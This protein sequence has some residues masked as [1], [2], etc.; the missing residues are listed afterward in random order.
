MLYENMLF[1]A[2]GGLTYTTNPA[3]V[4]PHS[5]NLILG[6]GN[7]GIQAMLQLKKKV[8]RDL[9]GDGPEDQPTRFG[10]LHFLGIDADPDNAQ[11]LDAE[12]FF[13]LADGSLGT[14]LRNKPLLEQDPALSWLDLENTPI[15]MMGNNHGGV[16]SLGRYL[17]V[18]KAGALAQV[19]YARCTA[20]L[21]HNRDQRLNVFL[22]T[23]L[24]GTIG[25][26]CYVDTCYL[27]RCL[28]KDSRWDL[29]IYG[30]FFLPDMGSIDT[31]NAPDKFARSQS[32]AR[33]YAALKELDY[34]RNLRENTDRFTMRY[35]EYL[36]VDTQEPPVDVCFLLAEDRDKAMNKVTE[37][38]LGALAELQTDPLGF[39]DI[40]F[41]GRIGD[42]QHGVSYMPPRSGAN[43]GYFTLGIAAAEH[44]DTL[45]LNY[46]GCGFF[47]EFFRFIDPA[48]ST[49]PPTEIQGFLKRLKL[50]APSLYRML[51]TGI[52]DV[53]LPA[54]DKKELAAQVM[55]PKGTLNMFWAQAGNDWL[56]HCQA[57]L[58]A[59]VAKLVQPVDYD[60]PGASPDS[61]CKEI[62]FSLRREENPF[63][64]AALLRALYEGDRSAMGEAIEDAENT[65]SREKERLRQADDALEQAKR[66]F[67]S[68]MPTTARYEAYYQAARQRFNRVLCIQTIKQVI[69]VLNALKEQLRSMDDEY[70][71]PLTQILNGLH[72]TFEANRNDPRAFTGEGP[73][74]CLT[75]LENSKSRM[76]DAVENMPNHG[77]TDLLEKLHQAKPAVLAREPEQLR[78]LVSVHIALT[79]RE[80]LEA[81]AHKTLKPSP[82][83]MDLPSADDP[84]RRNRLLN[85]LIQE[86]ILPALQAQAKPAFPLI[87]TLGPSMLL[88]TT[89]LRI[90]QP[91]FGMTDRCYT[92][93]GSDRMTT[94]YSHPSYASRFILEQW[95]AGFPLYAYDGLLRLKK[96]YDTQSKGGLH[97]HRDWQTLLPEPLPCSVYPE[98]ATAEAEAQTL[99]EAAEKQEILRRTDFDRYFFITRD[100]P[101]EQVDIT[102]LFKDD[103]PDPALCRKALEALQT[104]TARAEEEATRIHF[105]EKHADPML[106]QRFDVDRLVLAPKLLQQVRRELER[107]AHRAALAETLANLPAQGAAYDRDLDEFC[108]G[109]C[110]GLL[111]A[112]AVPNSQA[113]DPTALVFCRFINDYKELV[114][115][116]FSTRTTELG[117]EFPLYAAFADWRSL[118]RYATPREDLLSVLEA[119]Q[120]QPQT[121][122]DHCIARNLLD[123][124]NDNALEQL[125]ARLRDPAQWEIRRF[126]MG[127][128]RHLD[129][130]KEAAPC[131]PE[132]DAQLQPKLRCLPASPNRCCQVLD[133]Q[134]GKILLYYPAT[135]TQLVYDPESSLPRPL[136]P[137]MKVWDG[138]DWADP[139]QS[140][141]LY[142]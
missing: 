132:E 134:D 21:M 28:A 101:E 12:E 83:T 118:N 53:Q 18:K 36:Q 112:P 110:F 103:R 105:P 27:L 8:F 127:L 47:R 57:K 98:L 135:S 85:I 74:L 133:L 55:P 102:T 73:Y 31:A 71:R 15:P 46:L 104:A 99:L 23:D 142:L 140:D 81:P 1:S 22:F 120:T 89:S 92:L 84:S 59:A 43:A 40:P 87:P 49:V 32:N 117:R 95:Y 39:Q 52:P 3:R 80:F 94:L 17:L 79:F 78:S 141:I 19:L 72:Q 56:T 10:G 65:L 121:L 45:L 128:R 86:D 69:S 11:G 4:D 90:P 136:R 124:L 2:G 25:S 111:G 88:Q 67:H 109:L 66:K 29:H 38:V 9:S 37:H 51:R 30:Y 75:D 35:E 76:D 5:A 6:V 62:F 138:K 60:S 34:L 107:R 63:F 24:T 42:M 125:F 82:A 93:Y 97:L 131:W 33:C 130:W 20:G 116:Q 122:Q 61:L 119:L 58:D 44:S 64:A 26:S 137:D 68:K 77:I 100:T 108:Q 96:D 13:C 70:F 123:R 48:C 113:P 50:D 139:A 91:F 54:Y 106:R 129:R 126:Y 7:T 41:A 14:A 16:R 115:H 114:E